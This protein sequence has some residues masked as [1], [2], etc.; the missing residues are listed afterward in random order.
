MSRLRRKCPSPI[1]SWEYNTI[2]KLRRRFIQLPQLLR[3]L[4]SRFTVGH[5]TIFIFLEIVDE[6]TNGSACSSGLLVDIFE[7]IGRYVLFIQGN[8]EFALDF[9]A[10][11]LGVSQEP[12]E[13]RICLRIESLRNIMYVRRYTF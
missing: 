11:P 9:R 1:V 3:L 2:R 4:G 10:R 6:P 13:L 12:D 5:L 8:I 7:F